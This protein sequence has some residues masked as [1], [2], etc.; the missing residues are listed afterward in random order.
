MA[1]DDP[2]WKDEMD[3]EYSA[4]MKNSTWHLVHASAGKNV[5][6][7]KW[8]YEV[9]PRAD[10]SVDRFKACLVA[11]GFKQWYG[12]DTKIHLVL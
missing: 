1:L 10:G 3:E 8:I 6:G 2:K 9:N 4:L 12:I 7:C 5:I 11:K